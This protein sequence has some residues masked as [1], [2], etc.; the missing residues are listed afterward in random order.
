MNLVAKYCLMSRVIV[1]SEEEEG[2]AKIWQQKT[3]E[4]NTKE[5]IKGVGPY[6]NLV[7]NII[8]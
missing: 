4:V 1:A 6:T 3:S 7:L 2:E 5:M 8:E